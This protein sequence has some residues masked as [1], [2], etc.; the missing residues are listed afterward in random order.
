MAAHP[1]A[2]KAP[3]RSRCAVGHPTATLIHAGDKSC[4]PTMIEPPKFKLLDRRRP[5]CSKCGKPLILTA[6][7]RRNPVSTF[8]FIIVRVA[9]RTKPSWC[10]SK[11]LR[12]GSVGV[13]H[14]RRF[15]ALAPA[16][17]RRNVGAVPDAVT[18]PELAGPSSMTKGLAILLLIAGACSYFF[19]T[20]E[21]MLQIQPNLSLEE[22]HFYGAILGLGGLVCFAISERR[23]I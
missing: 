2:L 19:P 14:M 9:G 16:S 18:N 23:K 3:R 10:R 5:P 1:I 22:G 20:L 12:C 17:S 21:G 13:A 6:S 7:T 8:A 15:K 4:V 11:T